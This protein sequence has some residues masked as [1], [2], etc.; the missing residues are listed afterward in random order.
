MLDSEYAH[1]LIH[2]KTAHDLIDAMLDIENYEEIFPHGS[3]SEGL[4]S[5]I[6]ESQHT[7]GGRTFFERLLE[8][9]NIKCKSREPMFLARS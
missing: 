7:L 4:R 1:D 2:T 5:D 9:L 6:R 3:Y 8:L